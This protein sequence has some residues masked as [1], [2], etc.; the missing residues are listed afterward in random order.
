MLLL[1]EPGTLYIMYV[2]PLFRL[3]AL[4]YLLLK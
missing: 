4:L 3:L 1:S 2:L